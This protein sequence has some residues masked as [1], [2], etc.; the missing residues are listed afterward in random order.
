MSQHDP[1]MPPHPFTPEQHCRTCGFG[2]EEHIDF[3]ATLNDILSEVGQEVE[4]AQDNYPPFASAHE[5]LAIVEE[6]FDELKA[7][8]FKSPKRREHALMYEEAKQLAAMAVR[9]MLDVDKRGCV[10]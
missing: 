6:E 3:E 4:F 7:E 10:K 2:A 5:G 9:F 1:M 8:V